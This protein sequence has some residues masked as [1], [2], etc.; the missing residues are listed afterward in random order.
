MSSNDRAALLE[1]IDAIQD[2]VADLKADM[3]LA[4][5]ESSEQ[6]Q[7]RVSQERAGSAARQQSA[8][9]KARQIA[10]RAPSRWQ[11]MCA[12]AVAKARAFEDRL[13]EKH[14]EIE[15]SQAAG[16]AEVAEGDALD[17]LD[18]AWSAVERAEIAVLN[19]ID[20]RIRADQRAA[21]SSAEANE[22]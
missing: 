3:D 18:F 2:K 22:G 6:I 16:D 8:G 11:Q 13:Y 5:E 15:A 7:A 19:A 21:A 1:R 14:D 4:S 9:D 17:A 20:A 12:D 10:E